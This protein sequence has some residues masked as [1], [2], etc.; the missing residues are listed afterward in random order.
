MK[1]KTET[2]DVWNDRPVEEV[3]DSITDPNTTPAKIE[4]FVAQSIEESFYD[5]DGLMTDFPTAR[6]LERF[7]FDETGHVLNLKGRANKMKYQNSSDK[8]R[9]RCFM[10][11]EI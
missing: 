1:K 7:V 3:L 6:E 9:I 10:S 4:E 8:C 5:I 2:T 11:K